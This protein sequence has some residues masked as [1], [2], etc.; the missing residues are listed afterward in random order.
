MI[1]ID[2]KIANFPCACV[3][4]TRWHSS[5]CELVGVSILYKHGRKVA[6]IKLKVQV[7]ES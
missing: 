5:Q 2:C 1:S 6:R 3:L 4:N 7:S